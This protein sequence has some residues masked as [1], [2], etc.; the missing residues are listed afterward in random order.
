MAQSKD[1]RNRKRRER[2]ALNK[3]IDAENI[4]NRQQRITAMGNEITVLKQF[5]DE[6]TGIPME[7][8]FIPFIGTTILRPQPISI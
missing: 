4:T 3:Q 2:Y 7:I 8:V 5:I 6:E 1:E